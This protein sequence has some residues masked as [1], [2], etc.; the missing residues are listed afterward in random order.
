MIKKC[1]CFFSEM[2]MIEIVHR[3]Q[4]DNSFLTCN[5]SV[6]IQRIKNEIHE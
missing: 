6:T 1:Y 5:D 3:Q 4:L 2:K